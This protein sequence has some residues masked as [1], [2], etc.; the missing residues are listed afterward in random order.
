MNKLIGLIIAV[1]LTL[2]ASA[3]TKTIRGTL[4]QTVPNGKTTVIV[5]RPYRPY[6]N[7]Y[8][9]P[10]YGFN[11]WGYNPYGFYPYYGFGQA[12]VSAPSPLDLEIEQVRND[13]AHE[14]AS[15]RHDENMS[16]AERKQKIRDLKHERKNAI[17]DAKRNYYKTGSDKS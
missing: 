4:P 3:Q 1:G 5:V 2:G 14:L 10:Y 13:Y 7:P 15:V 16:K 8:Y 6:Y 17:I 9:S 11:R 12:R